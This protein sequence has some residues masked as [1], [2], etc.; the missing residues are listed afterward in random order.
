MKRLI[1]VAVLAVALVAPGGP[2]PAEATGHAKRYYL[3]LGDSL[4]ESAQLDGDLTHG[5][6]EQLHAA[7]TRDQPEAETGQVR[8]RWRVDG[9]DALRQPGP[10]HRVE[11]R[12]TA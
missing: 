3:S 1:I 8:L 11:L 9:V 5:Y 7:L 6:A 2:S 12:I 4:A 10:G